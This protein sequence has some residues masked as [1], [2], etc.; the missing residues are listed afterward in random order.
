[1]L[2]GWRSALAD[3]RSSAKKGEPDFVTTG[4]DAGPSE[5]EAAFRAA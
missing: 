3:E 1:L 5:I 4:G 2:T